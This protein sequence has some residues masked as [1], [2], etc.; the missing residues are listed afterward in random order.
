[1]WTYCANCDDLVRQTVYVEGEGRCCVGCA[2]YLG[3]KTDDDFDDVAID[4][5]SIIDPPTYAAY[6]EMQGR[7]L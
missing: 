6:A 5:P 3:A 2:E 7:N 4:E 1:M